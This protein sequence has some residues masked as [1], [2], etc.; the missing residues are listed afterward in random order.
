MY[1]TRFL[2]TVLVAMLPL[3]VTSA[4]RDLTHSFSPP[5]LQ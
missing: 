4:Q 5:S 3:L 2:G 1:F